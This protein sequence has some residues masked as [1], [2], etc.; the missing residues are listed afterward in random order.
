MMGIVR[1]LNEAAR[2]QRIRRR[3]SEL[4]RSLMSYKSLHK[5]DLPDL[6]KVKEVERLQSEIIEDLRGRIDVERCDA[7]CVILKSGELLGREKLDG[8]CRRAQ[9]LLGLEPSGCSPE[10]LAG[11]AETTSIDPDKTGGLLL[12]VQG[13]LRGLSEELKR[14]GYSWSGISHRCPVCGLESETMVRKGDGYYMVCHMCFFTW[15]VSRGIPVCP[16]CGSTVPLEVGIFT[17][18]SRRI[19]LGFCSRCG[20]SWRILLDQYMS[21]PDHAAPL[22]A[23]GAER[24]RPAMEKALEK[25]LEEWG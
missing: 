16:R 10:D 7:R 12:V 22:I 8:Y 5:L 14:Q 23:L 1:E 19:G 15:L 20:Y 11:L 3:V 21:V 2:A 13:L 24:F 6:E 4:V 17:D 18:K 25:G 9:S